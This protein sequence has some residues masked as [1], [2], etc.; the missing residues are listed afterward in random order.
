MTEQE[1]RK[2]ISKAM[3]YTVNYIDLEIDRALDEIAIK[4]R[5]YKPMNSIDVWYGNPTLKAEV[6]KILKKHF[7]NIVVL[8][9]NQIKGAWEASDKR[10]DHL[11]RDSLIGL[12]TTGIAA[13]KLYKWFNRELP[14][15]SDPGELFKFSMETYTKI[16][17]SPRIDKKR[18][19]HLRNLNLSKNVWNIAD[20]QVKPLIESFLSKGIN[21]GSS[22]NEIARGL[23]QYLKN[24]NTL[25]RRV[26]DLK[27]GKLKPSSRAMEYHP[28]QG[29][30]RSAFQNAKRLA[31]EEINFA[32]R[33]ADFDRWQWMDFVK[34]IE[35][36]LSNNHPIA[37]ICDE[38]QGFYPKDFF[39]CG[40]HVRCRCY[41]IPVL[42]DK[43]EFMEHVVDNKPIEGRIAAT[44]ESIKNWIKVNTDRL[45]NWKSKPY[46]LTLNQKYFPKI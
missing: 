19:A 42:P 43:D 23:K 13:K 33:Q 20:D 18:V 39:F 41:A 27:T 22:A 37:D 26:R 14:S 34:G 1:L 40:W 32:H 6:E 17:N 31:A 4:L 30:Y 2:S 10:N 3:I 46:F 21:D 8:T 44:P 45:Q 9:E 16:S 15:G 12:A 36:K 35:V 7:R 25:Y 29:V 24:P 11:L 28:G 5:G 38:A